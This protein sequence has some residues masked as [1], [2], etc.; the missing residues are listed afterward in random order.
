[1]VTVGVLGFLLLRGGDD[2]VADPA[3]DPTTTTPASPST[4]VGPT[5]TLSPPPTVFVPDPA[6]AVPVA[7]R[8]PVASATAPDG[9]DLS[10]NVV[11]YAVTNAVD[12]VNSTAWRVEGD[13]VGQTISVQ[14]DR[15]TYV[16]EVGLIPGYDKVDPVDGTDRFYENR[17]VRS[18][19]WE[20]D[21][22]VTQGQAFS[23][24]RRIQVT[25]V[26]AVLTTRVR[27]VIQET[28]AP[29]GRDFT[30]I[31]EIVVRGVPAP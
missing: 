2:E 1:M 8:S 24:D 20:F 3:S 12:G 9:N 19:R 14:F 29:G 26:A 25:Q 23:D 11:T 18:V 30:A 15:P 5:T 4:T 13:G 7:L 31:S 28:T 6:A 10:G 22:G 21:G 16:T 17:R 27:L